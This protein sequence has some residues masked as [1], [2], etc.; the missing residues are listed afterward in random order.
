MRFAAATALLALL[1]PVWA[2]AAFASESGPSGPLRFSRM[3]DDTGTIR[4]FAIVEEAYRRLGIAVE[5][6][7]LPAER[8]L[9]AAD[10]G[11]TDGDTIRVEGIDALYPNLVRVPEP[12]SHVDVLAFTTGLSFDVQG[13]ES[14]RPYTV[15][16][17]YG[18]KLHEQGTQDLRRMGAD[19]QENAVLLLRNGQCE[20][21]VLS[22]N[23]WIMIDKVN[24]GPMRELSPPIAR[25]QLYHYVHRRH[26]ALVPLLA[27]ELRKM[28]REGVVDAILAPHRQDVEAAKARQSMP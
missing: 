10:S 8:A 17:I 16:Y 9:R 4:F 12:V 28:K 1:L 20:V 2:G 26:T 21:A 25:H 6:E 15:C 5:A 19:G 27:E 23:A 22:A 7:P 13:W 24:A 18:A 11:L 3:A 14:L